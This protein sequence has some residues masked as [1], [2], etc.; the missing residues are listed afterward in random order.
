MTTQTQDK[1]SQIKIVEFFDA[2]G[3]PLRSVIE[4]WARENNI[5]TIEIKGLCKDPENKL[6]EYIVE[7]A[8]KLNAEAVI[9]LQYDEPYPFASSTEICYHIIF[10]DQ[11]GLILGIQ[12]ILC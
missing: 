11:Y 4:K 1:N 10:F 9:V 2:G 8:K 6:R 5:E 7:Q 3:S 12:E